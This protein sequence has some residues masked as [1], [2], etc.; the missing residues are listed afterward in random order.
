VLVF[1][2]SRAGAT[3]KLAETMSVAMMMAAARY[4]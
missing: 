3:M 1:V 4:A 2:V